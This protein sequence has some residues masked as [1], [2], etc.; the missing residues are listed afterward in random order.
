VAGLSVENG[1]TSCAIAVNVEGNLVVAAREELGVRKVEM[2]EEL[3]VLIG[4][5][6]VES[7]ALLCRRHWSG[8]SGRGR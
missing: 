6:Q 4:P 7:E 3:C 1:T 8:C 2:K 5:V